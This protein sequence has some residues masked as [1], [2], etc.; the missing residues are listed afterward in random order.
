MSGN[1]VSLLFG[2]YRR[3]V[4]ALLFLHLET[5]LHV[6]EIARIIGKVPGTLLR[7][8]NLL[9]EA[10]LLNNLVRHGLVQ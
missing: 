7:E 1:L 4:L 9:A 10:G 6:R 5:S 3:D 8:L 2:T